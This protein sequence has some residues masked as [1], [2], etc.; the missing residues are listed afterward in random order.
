M[1][2]VIFLLLRMVNSNNLILMKQLNS[3]SI[4]KMINKK[5]RYLLSKIMMITLSQFSKRTT[6]SHQVEGEFRR[7]SMIEN[8]PTPD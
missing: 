5:S 8:K 3:G 7:T 2:V 6:P 1:K 4:L